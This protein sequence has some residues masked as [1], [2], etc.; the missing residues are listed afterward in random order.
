MNSMTD[1]GSFDEYL[2]SLDYE[3]EEEPNNEDDLYYKDRN[4]E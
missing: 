4:G 3:G 1:C 2:K